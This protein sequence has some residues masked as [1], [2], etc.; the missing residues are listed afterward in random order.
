[1]VSFSLL[2]LSG[3]VFPLT[4]GYAIARHDLFEADRFVKLTLVYAVITALVSLAYAGALLAVDGLAAGLVFSR[5]PIFPIAFVLVALATVVPLRDR[6][7]R[8]VDRLFYR[9]RVDYKETVAR[10]SERMTTLLDRDAIVQHLLTALR[11][12][13]FIDGATLW[14][15]EEGALVRR[16]GSAGVRC[17]PVGEPG[18]AVFEARGGGVSRDEA[19][20]SARLWRQR[21]ALR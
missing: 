13:L 12:V 3:F 4:I 7:Q 9:G 16:G 20:E 10:A 1:P 5:S 17:I 21:D 11:E 2:T 8:A 14:E 18:L 6:V 15:R 19:E